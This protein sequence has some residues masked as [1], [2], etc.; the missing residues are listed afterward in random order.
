GP[1]DDGGYYLL[2]AKQLSPALFRDMVWSTSDVA[3]ETLR[4]CAALALRTRVVATWPDVDDA[5]ALRRLVA[6][7]RGAP[8]DVAPPTRG[9]LVLFG[10]LA[11]RRCWPGP[12]ILGLGLALYL[13]AMG[14]LMPLTGA[15][16]F[17]TALFQN[18][19]LVNGLYLGVALAYASIL[20]LG[21]VT[22]P[23]LAAR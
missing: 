15:G 16:F 9:A 6:A 10:A 7:L 17:A 5:G 20:V 14:G 1:S 18:V 12:A 23:L 13:V 21:Q 19:Y 8:P 3:Q 2:A 22:T 11:L 4:R